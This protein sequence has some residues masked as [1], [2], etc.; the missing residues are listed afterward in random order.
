MVKYLVVDPP[1]GWKYGFPKIWDFKPSHPN[2]PGEN[3]EQ[4]YKE[5]FLDHGYP[6]KL[7]SQGMLEHCRYWES[8]EDIE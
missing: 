2:L 6:Q 1:E 8:E 7:V 3:Y 4:E 5:W